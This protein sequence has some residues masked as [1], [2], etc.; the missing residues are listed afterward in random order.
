MRPNIE[1]AEHQIERARLQLRYLY[2]QQTTQ[3]R[4]A[5]IHSAIDEALRMALAAL[6][7]GEE[8]YAIEG[9][10]PSELRAP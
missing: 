5:A 9:W 2:T 8:R 6:R 3:P 10:D 1:Q 7:R 4:E